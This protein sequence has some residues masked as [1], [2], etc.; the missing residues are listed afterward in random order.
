VT[1]KDEID[2]SRKRLQHRM[3]MAFRRPE[4]RVAWEIPDTWEW[5]MGDKGS[6]TM[7]KKLS[8]REAIIEEMSGHCPRVHNI[9][10][11]CPPYRFEPK[12]PS[13]LH[14]EEALQLFEDNWGLAVFLTSA[15]SPPDP[16]EVP[17]HWHDVHEKIIVVQGCGVMRVEAQEFEMKCQ[18]TIDVPAGAIHGATLYH[19]LRAITAYK[20][21]EGQRSYMGGAP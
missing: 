14:L 12:I 7:C 4:M 20:T 9:E 8:T 2:Q 13:C 5:M 10:M 19:P 16:V 6:R 15:V 1:Y 18:D 21:K 11:P 3:A 17:L